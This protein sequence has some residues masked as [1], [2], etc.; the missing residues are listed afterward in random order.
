MRDS[1]VG[2]LNITKLIGKDSVEIKATREFSSKHPVFPM[3]LVKHHY[4]TAEYKFPSRGKNKIPKGIVKVEDSPGSVKKIIKPRKSR[5]SGK[6]NRKYLVRLKKQTDDK[7]KWLEEDEIR[8]G[9]LNL[10]RFRAS[11]RF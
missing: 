11:R 2:P 4:Q 3:I 10:K 8:D 9:K 5:L 6:D 1:F 7:D